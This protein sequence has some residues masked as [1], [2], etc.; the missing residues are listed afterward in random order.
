VSF[1]GVFGIFT[2]HIACMANFWYFVYME[3]DAAVFHVRH[4][5]LF[6]PIFGVEESQLNIVLDGEGVGRVSQIL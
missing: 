6:K 5:M 4:V 1:G 2:S 3:T